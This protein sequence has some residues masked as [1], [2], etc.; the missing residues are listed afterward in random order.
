MICIK[1]MNLNLRTIT[2][3]SE[4]SITRAETNNLVIEDSHTVKVKLDTE[5]CDASSAIQSTWKRP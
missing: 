2:F 1:L 5:A 4:Q 3:L